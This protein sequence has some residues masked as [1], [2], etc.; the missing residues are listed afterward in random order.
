MSIEL[1]NCLSIYGTVY[2]T[3]H[4]ISDTEEF[5]EWTETNFNYVKYNPRK[6]VNRYGLSLTSLDGS[7]SGIPDLDSLYEYNKENQ[8][9]YREKD[10]RT[11]TPVYEYEDLKKCIQPIEKYLFR[12]HILKLDPGGFFP[13]HRDFRG[14]E[15]DSYRIIIP[16]SNMTPPAFNFIVDDKL[17]HWNYGSLYFVDTVKTHYLFNASFTP[18]YM[19]VLNVG[20]N[21]ET[22]NFIT[23]NLKCQ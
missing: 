14:M 22:I 19:M 10:F 17:Q 21:E 20:L 6:K 2:E 11:F 12:S 4:K 16:L 23:K 13:P 8:T 9:T 7:V 3:T 1:Y 15:F 5:V 18:S